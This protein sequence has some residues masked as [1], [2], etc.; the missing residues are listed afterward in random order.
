LASDSP[1]VTDAGVQFECIITDYFSK[2]KPTEMA[3]TFFH[4]TGSQFT[5]QTMAVK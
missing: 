2:D 3:I 4:P 1:T 5:N